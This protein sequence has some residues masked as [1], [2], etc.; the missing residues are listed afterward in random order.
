MTG[1]TVAKS[2]CR[3]SFLFWKE[4]SG[5]RVSAFFPLIFP[6]KAKGSL[7]QYMNESIFYRN[8]DSIEATFYNGY[9]DPVKPRC[10]SGADYIFFEVPQ[11]L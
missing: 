7:Y 11:V 3:C 8:P 5:Y 1:K 2:M 10:S 4:Q 6:K 9:I